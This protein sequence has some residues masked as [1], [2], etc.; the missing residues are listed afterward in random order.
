MPDLAGWRRERMPEIP[1]GVAFTIL[2]DWVCEILSPA[3]RKLDRT[4]KR[5]R[6]WAAGVGHHRLVD[7]DE[8]TLEAFALQHD[9]WVL[10]ASRVDDDAVRLAPFEAVSYSLGALWPD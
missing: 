4:A 9:A 6:Y 1:A 5:D 10:A 3:T 7:P 2:P 8:R